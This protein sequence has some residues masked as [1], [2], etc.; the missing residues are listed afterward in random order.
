MKHGYQL[1]NDKISAFDIFDLQALWTF[2]LFSK[3]VE[4]FIFEEWLLNKLQKYEWSHRTLK[5]DFVW[6]LIWPITEL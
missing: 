1:V 2:G 5:C 6:T 4:V 3:I